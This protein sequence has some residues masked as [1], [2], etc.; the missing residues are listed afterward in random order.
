MA[1][2]VFTQE[3]ICTLLP[4]R[5]PFLFVN[6]V[7]RFRPGR[8]ITAEYD[9][10]PE[11]WY[12]RG[13]FPGHPIVPGVVLTDALAQTAGL[14][15]GFTKREQESGETPDKPELFYLAADS[16]KYVETVRPGETVTLTATAESSFGGLFKYQVEASC[17]RKIVA[18]G[19]MTLAIQEGGLE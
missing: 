1:A 6:R 5:D 19:D 17:G 4:H 14:L 3:D 15:W 9:V 2:I 7:V 16:M 8:T 11:S 13:H 18:R 10:D 12:F